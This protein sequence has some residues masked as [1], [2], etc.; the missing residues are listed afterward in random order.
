MNRRTLL[1]TAAAAPLGAALAASGAPAPKPNFSVVDEQPFSAQ[2]RRLKLMAGDKLVS[3]LLFPTEYPTHFRLKPELYPVC[4]PKGFPVTGTHNYCFI[5]H[6]SVMCGHGKVL[7]EG[8]DKPLDFYRKLNF[9]E[10]TRS[11]RC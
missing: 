7:V 4:T 9:P 6:Q 5:H 2:T 10:E 3:A 8:R 1:K 11:D